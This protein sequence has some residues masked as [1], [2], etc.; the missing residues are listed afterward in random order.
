VG[1]LNS[2]LI[3]DHQIRNLVGVL[4]PFIHP[5]LRTEFILNYDSVIPEFFVDKNLKIKSCFYI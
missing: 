1:D 3:E 2:P 5:R 4:N